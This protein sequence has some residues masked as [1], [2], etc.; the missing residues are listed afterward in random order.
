MQVKNEDNAIDMSSSIVLKQG[1]LN[2]KNERT[3]RWKT[4]WTILKED[5]LEYYRKR[6][7]HLCS[8]IILSNC[9]VSNVN[10][11]ETK[12][13]N[14][15][16]VILSKKKRSVIFQAASDSEKNYWLSLIGAAIR[17]LTRS[18]FD[19]NNLVDLGYNLSEILVSMEDPTAG[20]QLKN[21]NNIRCFSGKEAIDWLLNWDFA[22]SRQKGF[23]IC[24]QLT[25]GGYFQQIVPQQKAKD[26]QDRDFV[27]YAFSAVSSI[28]RISMIALLE[29]STEPSDSTS[30][31]DESEDNLDRNRESLLIDI[32][33]IK[34]NRRRNWRVRKAV[35]FQDPKEIRLYSSGKSLQTDYKKPLKVINLEESEA[36]CLEYV[37]DESISSKQN[38]VVVIKRKALRPVLLQCDNDYKRDNWIKLI[39]LYQ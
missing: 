16:K 25:S 36:V 5:C 31:G 28:R 23:D 18:S 11:N 9:S 3:G 7:K 12:R 22:P 34:S 37:N 29:S 8:R 15:F 17:E 24:Q 13:E 19:A 14:T 6:C 20:L 4:R 35:L 32:I 33:R 39:N 27:M 26:F 21:R 10:Q 30:S 1:Y 2:Q 38:H